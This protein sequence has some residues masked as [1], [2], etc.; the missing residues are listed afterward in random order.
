MNLPYIINQQRIF[1]SKLILGTPYVKEIPFKSV[2]LSSLQNNINF[3]FPKPVRVIPFCLRSQIIHKIRNCDYSGIVE[4]Y[5]PR[6]FIYCLGNVI[7]K[8]TKKNKYA[9]A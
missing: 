2:E 5:H 8:P 7:P 6:F 4:I 9:P 1:P 3:I